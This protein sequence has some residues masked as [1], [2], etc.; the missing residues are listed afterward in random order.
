MW[1]GR[2]YKVSFF[3]RVLSLPVIGLIWA[4]LYNPRLGLINSFP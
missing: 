4:W 2:I 1:G 3:R